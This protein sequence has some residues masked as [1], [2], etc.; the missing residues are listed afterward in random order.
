[1]DR[2]AR[3]R[4]EV[5]ALE[6]VRAALIEPRI[7]YALASGQD[8]AALE[9]AADAYAAA[10]RDTI[11]EAGGRMKIVIQMPGLPPVEVEG[12]GDLRPDSAVD[13]EEASATPVAVSRV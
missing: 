5:D 4:G 3:L 9:N 13:E 11:E 2:A 7:G 10:L 1:M 12:L 6:V 8:L